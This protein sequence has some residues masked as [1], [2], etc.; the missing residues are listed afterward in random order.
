VR[1]QLRA[2]ADSAT[3]PRVLKI[4][5]R[6]GARREREFQ[7]A[8][9]ARRQRGASKRWRRHGVRGL[10]EPAGSMCR[11]TVFAYHGPRPASKK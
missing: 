10:P 11:S 3:G 9:L 8:V 1:G 5:Y 6:A 4:E 7:Q 2:I